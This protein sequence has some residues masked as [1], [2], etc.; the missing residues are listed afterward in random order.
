MEEPSPGRYK[1][2]VDAS[3]SNSLNKVGITAC[4]QWKKPSPGR[5]KCNVDASFSNSLNKV[6]I[7]VCI[8]DEEG[9]F[10]LAKTEWFAPIVDVD[11]G[12]AMGLLTA[13]QWVKDLHLL[14]MDF[15]LDSKTVVDSVYGGRNGVSNYMAIINDCRHM[16]ATDIANSDLKFIRRQANGVAHSFRYIKNKIDSG[17]IKVEHTIFILSILRTILN[18]SIQYCLLYQQRVRY[19]INQYS[20]ILISH[21]S[22]N[23]YGLFGA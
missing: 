14:N 7:D 13:M 4:V 5:Y 18:V 1:C 16:L 17:I 12:E 3:F 23:L 11:L 21:L 10:V 20:P 6:G 2:N 9:L 8:R 19:K 22:L 15:E